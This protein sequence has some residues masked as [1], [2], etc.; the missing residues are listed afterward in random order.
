MRHRE[1]H[2]E[3][4]TAAASSE[5]RAHPRSAPSLRR[6]VLDALAMTASAVGFGVVY[7][8]A[9]RDAGFSIVEALA[10]SV[11]VLAGASQFAAVGLVAQGLPWLAIVGFTAMLNARHLLYSAALAPWLQ[12][13]P[14][15]ERAAMAHVLTDETFALVLPQ[16]QRLGRADRR[17]YWVAA[18]LVCVPWIAATVVGFVGGQAIPD[19]AALGL[20]VVFPAAMAGIALAL[21][22]DRR[23]VVAA[24]SGVAIAVIGG[25]AIDPAIGIVAAGV[26]APLVAMLLVPARTTGV[27]AWRMTDRPLPVADPRDAADASAGRPAP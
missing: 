8:L 22:T 6:L 16:W 24:V 7:G 20:D 27:P 21:I 19:P 12:R 1:R 26:L 9:A 11:F 3:R 23:D 4:A 2:G 17:G 18:G 25:V 13:T 5:A 10:M 15:V 14:R